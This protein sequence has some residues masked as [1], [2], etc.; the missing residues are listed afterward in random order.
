MIPP[1][2]YNRNVFTQFVA[3]IYWVS[4]FL[5]I[6]LILG[7]LNG[8]ATFFQLNVQLALQNSKC[9]N[10]DALNLPRSNE[11]IKTNAERNI[12]LIQNQFSISFV[13]QNIL[14]H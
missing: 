12:M 4:Q 11:K 5:G 7:Y 1:Q 3:E 9:S 10:T 8:F 14:Y 13:K 6:S 2:W